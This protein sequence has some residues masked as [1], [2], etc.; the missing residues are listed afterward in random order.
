MSV[1][2]IVQS[3]NTLAVTGTAA[4]TNGITLQSGILRV[5]AASTGCHIQIGVSP[6]ATTSSFYVS[7]NQPEII[8]ERVA[9]QRIGTATTGTNTLLT[10]QENA[11]NPFVVG[12]YVTIENTSAAG[13][14]A[15]HN[16]VIAASD[17]SI[18]INFNSA[19]ITGIGI[20]N[21]TVARSVKISSIAAGTATNLHISE[22]QIVGG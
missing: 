19:S 5:S 8:K 12:D 10:F 9:R 13:F 14:N 7:P 17:N 6:I 16:E 4:T 11:G 3:V 20:T 18:L 2:K 1:L 21:S 22:V 15:S